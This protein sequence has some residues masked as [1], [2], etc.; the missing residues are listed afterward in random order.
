MFQETMYDG[1]THVV[2]TANDPTGPFTARLYVGGD[3]ATLLVK[4]SKNLETIRSKACA[5]LLAHY[6]HCA[7]RGVSA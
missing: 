6:M 2:I 5:M 7:M 3:T 4:H 1:R